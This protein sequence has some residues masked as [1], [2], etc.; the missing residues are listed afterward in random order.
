[1]G[2]FHLLQGIA[3]VFLAYTVIDKIA[4]FQPI[5]VQNYLILL[6]VKV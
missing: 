5:I 6:L 2:V 4:T 3:M 1:M